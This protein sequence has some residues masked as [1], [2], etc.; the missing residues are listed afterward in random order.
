MFNDN[1]YIPVEFVLETEGVV[2]FF[3]YFLL[4]NTLLPISLFVSLESIKFG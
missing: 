3:R 1:F 2:S 4:L